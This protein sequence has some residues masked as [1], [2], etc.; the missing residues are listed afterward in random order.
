MGERKKHRREGGLYI[1]DAVRVSK[2]DGDTVAAAED[3]PRQTR[4]DM[5]YR[6]L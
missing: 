3:T 5:I 2:I 1:I 4:C 6:V